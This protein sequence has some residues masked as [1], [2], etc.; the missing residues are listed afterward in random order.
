[1]R[2]TVRR[3]DTDQGFRDPDTHDHFMETKLSRL[4]TT[5]EPARALW[6]HGPTVRRLDARQRS[7]AGSHNYSRLFVPQFSLIF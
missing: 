6:K 3:L 5:E 4:D 2:P 7:A 1:M